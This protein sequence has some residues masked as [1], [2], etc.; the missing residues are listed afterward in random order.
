MFHSRS[1]VQH[2]ANDLPTAKTS[3]VTKFWQLG[4]HTNSTIKI[5]C[6]IF[7]CQVQCDY[8]GTTEKISFKDDDIPHFTLTA[9][10]FYSLF[11]QVSWSK[12]LLLST[13]D[14]TD[15]VLSINVNRP[16]RQ[17]KVKIGENTGKAMVSF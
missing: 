3:T 8:P 6:Q 16:V 12:L 13:D 17:M 15:V 11:G 7:Y 5:N 9:V 2:G 1:R 10:P 4:G 14:H